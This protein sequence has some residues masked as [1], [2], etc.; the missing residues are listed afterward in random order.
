MW[1]TRTRTSGSNRQNLIEAL[2]AEYI[3]NP[4]ELLGS[5]I[6]QLKEAW[7]MICVLPRK[8]A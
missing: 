5:H 4:S 3:Q 8:A 7:G 2:E 6:L 1:S